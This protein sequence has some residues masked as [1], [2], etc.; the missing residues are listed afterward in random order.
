ML[1]RGYTY[2]TANTGLSTATSPAVG[3]SVLGWP[4]CP[5]ASADIWTSNAV[6]GELRNPSNYAQ[7][8]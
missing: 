2:E 1:V 3:S 8:N 4:V 6:T 7:C 5:G